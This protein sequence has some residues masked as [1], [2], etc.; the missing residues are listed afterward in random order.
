MMLV[1]RRLIMDALSYRSKV[2]LAI[3]HYSS[4]FKLPPLR[5]V[6]TLSFLASLLLGS[7]LSFT[8]GYTQLTWQIFK[9]LLFGAMFFT[10]TLSIDY[11]SIRLLHK[12]DIVLG[13]FRRLSFLSFLSNLLF[14]IFVGIGTALMFLGLNNDVLIKAL[15]ICLFA[16]LSLRLLVICT[17]S[18]LR[19]SFKIL[20]SLAQPLVTLLLLIL[21][22]AERTHIPPLANYLYSIILPLVFSIISVLLF[23]LP[24]NRDGIKTLGIP[25]LKI[26]RAFLANWAE[27]YEEPFE[28]ILERISEERD[29]SVSMLIFRGK[30]RGNIKA[31]IIVPNIHP[32]PFKNI[33][34][35]PLPSLIKDYVERE[36]GGIA[37]V[38][39][40][41]SG[42]ELDLPSQR[43]N[44]KVIN[45]IVNALKEPKNF[46]DRAT[47]FF[48]VVNDKAKVGCQIFDKC[49]FLTLTTSPETMEDL[50]LEL[51]EDITR[52]AIKEGFSWAIPVDAHNS[53]NGPFNMEKSVKL[54]REAAHE[55]LEEAK[56][57]A[58][59]QDALM[60]GAG[61]VIPKGLGLKEG[62]GPGGITAVVIDVDG[63][64]TAYVTIDGNN[65]VSGLREKILL[66]LRDLGI[67]CGEV[68][69]TDTHA[70]NAVVLT[71]RGY[72]PIGEVINHEDLVR[73]VKRAA[74]EA[75]ENME[76]SEVAWHKI[77]IPNVKVIGE[78]KIG[79]LSM[80]VDRISRKAKKYSIIFIILGLLLVLFL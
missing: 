20:S 36:F 23:T 43:E 69:T 80:L 51:N 13:S 77:V 38:P 61:N 19:I 74:S 67:K 10:A 71:K 21:V 42:H 52:K 48:T 12:R 79:E 78:R 5:T 4:L 28:E 65:M 2:D 58:Y 7:A 60:V 11:L 75:L 41:I 53:I 59:I 32:G 68:F 30:D 63:Q 57:L 34:S 26:F 56:S 46:S 62:I 50:P 18:F 44:M 40:G 49:A 17:V 70:V 35:S 33:G 6:L 39:H 1:W 15:S 27:N 73:N 64:K 37:S 3:K 8:R 66:S 9:G 72:H 16:T 47:K 45:S 54:L 55:A 29:V 76:P 22:Q 31:I 25:S 14:A 24:L